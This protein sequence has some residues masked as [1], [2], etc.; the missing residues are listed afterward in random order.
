MPADEAKFWYMRRMLRLTTSRSFAGTPAIAV[1]SKA[2]ACGITRARIAAP[3][4]SGGRPLPGCW[5]RMRVTS[6]I[7]TRRVTTRDKVETSMLVLGGNV[8]LTLAVIVGEHREDA[9][10]R[11]A[12]SVTGERVLPEVDHQEPADAVDE[13][14]KIFAEIEARAIGHEFEIPANSWGNALWA[15]LHDVKGGPGWLGRAVGRI[16]AASSR[17]QICCIYNSWQRAA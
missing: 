15:G 3:S 9:P 11:D 8:D 1:R 2:I 4:A 10:H 12:Q 7:F 13:I 14:G 16:M 5:S 6:P 17:N